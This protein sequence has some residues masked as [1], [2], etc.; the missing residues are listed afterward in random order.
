[1]DMRDEFHGQ[2]AGELSGVYDCADRMVLLAYNKHLQSGGGIRAFWRLLHKGSDVGLT[3]EHL[4]DMAGGMSRR[5]WAYC[6]EHAITV[7]DAHAG[8]R[9]GDDAAKYIPDVP[10]FTGLFLVQMSIAPAPVWHVE[11]HRQDDYIIKVYRPKKW[12][13]VRHVFFH[14][15]DPQW[16]HVTVRMCA[17]PPFGA[18]I[19]ING[20]EWVKRRAQAQGVHFNTDGNCFIEGSDFTRLDSLCGTLTAVPAGIRDAIDRWIY[21]SCLC[22]GLTLEQQKTTGFRYE[23]STFQVEYSRNYIFNRG[24]TLEQI[25][26]S[27]VDR[28]RTALGLEQLKTILGFKHRPR[29]RPK[30]GIMRSCNARGEYDLTTLSI[31]WGGFKLKL[32]DKSARLLRAEVTVNNA[33]VLRQARSLEHIDGILESLRGILGRFMDNVQAMNSAFIGPDELDRWSQPGRVGQRR[34][35]GIN[36][37]NARIRTVLSLLPSLSIIPGGFS[38]A[39]LQEAVR[40]SGKVRGYTIAQARYDLGKLRSKRL[41]CRPKG[42]RKYEVPGKVVRQVCAYFT[43]N[44]EI[45]R[46]LMAAGARP[47][48]GRPPK[49]EHPADVIRLCIRDN[50]IEL[51]SHL[52]IAV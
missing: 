51:F 14:F 34:M 18:M 19:M 4:A 26:R 28:T 11:R 12:S 25:Y 40:K 35:A 37:N 30:I 33:K 45:I 10:G 16:G 1:M 52:G 32:Y 22:F 47:Q 46:P 27:L 21:S 31:S 7:L 41:M 23:Y 29:T 24:D 17:H 39:D 15:M 43:L 36:L 6:K 20:H 50:L 5:I 49:H 38:S 8:D 13:N 3:S 42:R 44:D 2:Y 48:R 9:K